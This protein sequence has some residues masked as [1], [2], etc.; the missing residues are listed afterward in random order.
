MTMTFGHHTPDAELLKND[1]DRIAASESSCDEPSYLLSTMFLDTVV[2]FALF[3]IF[4]AHQQG[5]ATLTFAFLFGSLVLSRVIRPK[6]R[7]KVT[8]SSAFLQDDENN[9]ANLGKET[10]KHGRENHFSRARGQQQD[11]TSSGRKSDDTN[12]R[13]SC[14]SR[15]TIALI[16]FAICIALAIPPEGHTTSLWATL[17]ED[18]KQLQDR[19]T[20]SS[21]VTKEAERDAG[22]EV[23]DSIIPRVIRKLGSEREEKRRS[24]SVGDEENNAEKLPDG[25]NFEDGRSF[26]AR[27]KQTLL[28]DIGTFVEDDKNRAA[29]P[30]EISNPSEVRNG[31]SGDATGP[32]DSDR[33][34]GADTNTNR[35]KDDN[36]S[37]LASTSVELPVKLH[38]NYTYEEFRNK[39]VSIVIPTKFEEAY[40]V[41]TIK[42][43][44]ETT[45]IELLE[46]VIIVDDLSPQPV[47]PLFE[48]AFRDKDYWILHPDGHEVGG[49]NTGDE[50]HQVVARPEVEGE[51]QIQSSSSSAS[52]AAATFSSS[53]SVTD[54]INSASFTGHVH[55]DPNSTS[56]RTTTLATSMEALLVNAT[57][58]P[59]TA[60]TTTSLS[61]VKTNYTGFLSFLTSEQRSTLKILRNEV[62]QGLIRSKIQGGHISTGSH[63]FFLDGHCQPYKFWLEP[64][65]RRALENDQRIVLPLVGDINAT[66]LD[67]WAPIGTSGGAKMMFEWNFEFDWFDDGGDDV[68]IMSGGLLLMSRK[69][70]DLVGGYDDGMADWGGE[71]I[72]QSMRTWIC[73]GEVV[74]ERNSLV[75]HIFTRP[76]NPKKVRPKSVERNKARAAY[77][78]LDES[79]E[80]HFLPEQE[81]AR[82]M[83]LGNFLLTRVLFRHEFPT[84]NERTFDW[85]F[86]EKFYHVFETRG[87][88][89]SEAHHI[90]HTV[91]ALC[92]TGKDNGKEE[93]ATVHLQ[94]CD[95]YNQH[96]KWSLIT[97]ATRLVNHKL[98][99]CLDRGNDEK[100]KTPILY[101]CDHTNANA[102]QMWTFGKQKWAPKQG[103]RFNN[104]VD[105]EHAF[106]HENKVLYTGAIVSDLNS[107]ALAVSVSSFRPLKC[108]TWSDSADKQ[109]Y[110]LEEHTIDDVFNVNTDT[111]DYYDKLAAKVMR[112]RTA[113]IVASQNNRSH[114]LSKGDGVLDSPA[115]HLRQDAANSGAS[116]AGGQLV[117]P[118]GRGGTA[119]DGLIGTADEEPGPLGEH[120]E[121]EQM[122]ESDREYR[123]QNKNY[124]AVLRRSDSEEETTEPPPTDEPGMVECAGESDA[125]FAEYLFDIIW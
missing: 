107:K 111:L 73:G 36:T 63:I 35:T 38:A 88:V 6:R 37:F 20:W 113:R 13:V 105:N 102:N 47:L 64:L 56:S 31:E 90:R 29:K 4:Q 66:N 118:D 14:A 11:I 3:L 28:P 9:N 34:G 5:T 125:Q 67:K 119:E 71:N 83:D 87:L 86:S 1:P 81:H 96:Q 48:D 120:E 91:S 114:P 18:P 62:H 116:A 122:S 24:L 80:K 52:G 59:V 50:G 74:V 23:V 89:L 112:R 95:A 27:M 54:V 65:L 7:G 30:P 123:K 109:D 25:N 77:V 100:R 103:V 12:P 16:L 15:I 69:W 70:W 78:W 101:Q 121:D 2:A 57:W 26:Y 94:P 61:R 110:D 46:E 99:K 10:I 106:V 75:G 44:Y 93:L 39:T 19:T 58:G 79:Y 45:P 72:E 84:C 82:K 55:G 124:D 98:K 21:F 68:P 32:E 92:L 76:A 49:V 115:D 60:S 22:S 8:S 53:S 51:H 104:H 97:N 42:Y 33:A 40:I 108:L 41:K 85:W 117:Q 43:I 17:F